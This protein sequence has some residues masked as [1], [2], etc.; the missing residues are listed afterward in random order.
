MF[1]GELISHV[2][3]V[4][5]VVA[6]GEG[7][8]CQA[9]GGVEVQLHV[10][11]AGLCHQF[12][13]QDAGSVQEWLDVIHRQR[14]PR[15]VRELHQVLDGIAVKVPDLDQLLLGFSHFRQKHGSEVRDNAC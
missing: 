2:H 15:R 8:D 1:T 10:L 6:L 5:A 12:H 4:D 11:T 7:P 3:Q 14:E 13:L 9:V